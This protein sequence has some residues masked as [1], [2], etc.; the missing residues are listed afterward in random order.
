MSRFA[1]G[2]LYGFGCCAVLMIG[3]CAGARADQV[4]LDDGTT[5]NVPPGYYVAILP[6]YVTHCVAKVIPEPLE[7]EPSEPTCE[8][9]PQYCS[10]E[11]LCRVWPDHPKCNVQQECLLNPDAPECICKVD[12]DNPKCNTQQD[13]LFLNRGGYK[14]N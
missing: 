1:V 6:D 2:F 9:A 4:I 7:P 5:F 11:E 12:P 3:V 10:S 14:W 8:D 13:L